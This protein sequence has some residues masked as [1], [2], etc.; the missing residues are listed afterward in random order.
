MCIH[1]GMEETEH[2]QGR[3][4]SCKWFSSLLGESCYDAS[5][6]KGKA[7]IELVDVAEDLA[8]ALLC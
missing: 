8:L 3:I 1:F 4:H 7:K 5:I 6:D 2:A